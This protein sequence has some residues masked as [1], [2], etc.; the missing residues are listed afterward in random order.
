[1]DKSLYYYDPKH[2]NCLRI[3]NKVD[4]NIYI[5]NGAYGSDEGK[6]GY[7][8]ATAEKKK[9]FYYKGD[10][11]NLVVNFF[12]KKKIIHKQ[13]YYAYMSARKIKWQDGNTWIQLYA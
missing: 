4:T 12:L 11:Y 6:N 2:G 9:N 10:K 1:M 5:I 8:A 3:M 13:I 7:W